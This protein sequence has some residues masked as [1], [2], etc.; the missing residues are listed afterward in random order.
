[1]RSWDTMTDTLIEDGMKDGNM[2]KENS[3]LVHN[4]KCFSQYMDQKPLEPPSD[5][6]RFL[7][8]KEFCRFSST[9][10]AIIDLTNDDDLGDNRDPSLPQVATA[11]ATA[12]PH[13]PAGAGF[14]PAVAARATQ[15][16]A[17]QNTSTARAAPEAA[18][19]RNPPPP[20]A[21][22]ALAPAAPHQTDNTHLP[23]AA[24]VRATNTN[25]AH[26]APEATPRV[27]FA[28]NPA[29]QSTGLSD[30]GDRGSASSDQQ[31]RCRKRSYS[32]PTTRQRSNSSRGN[33]YGLRSSSR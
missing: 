8:T 13:H 1:M 27:H 9:P 30:H 33:T 19:P 2:S 3:I 25:A 22:T 29:H 14:P 26:E 6:G 10:S 23:H 7:S 4:R 18:T 16:L 15:L 21:A 11:P 20:L 12:T 5:F 28:I 32:G 17:T 31:S 24:A